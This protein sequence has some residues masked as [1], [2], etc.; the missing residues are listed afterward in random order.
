MKMKLI[1]LILII[2][3]PI[4]TI[5]EAKKLE[6]NIDLGVFPLKNQS[7]T[8]FNWNWDTYFVDV[9]EKASIINNIQN[10]I[11]NISGGLRWMIK[12]NFGFYISYSSVNYNIDSNSNYDLD[13]TWFD[14]E[15]DSMSA[16]WLKKEGRINFTPYTI[17]ILFRKPISA[18]SSVVIKGGLSLA[19]TKTNF[20]GK[21]GFAEAFETDTEY[22][23][24]WYALDIEISESEMLKGGNIALEYEKR[25]AMSFDYYIGIEYFFLPVKNYKWKVTTE[26]FYDQIGEQTIIIDPDIIHEVDGDITTD[27]KFSNM[28]LYAG[29]RYYF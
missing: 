10:K 12:E 18:S 21:V 27:I 22:R 8:G 1:L 5:L 25:I 28:R 15:Y 6:L 9:T 17:G 24:N 7:D 3:F 29:I 16:D 19:S 20:Y 4:N 11:V 23:L 13:Y 26:L 14:G 2:V